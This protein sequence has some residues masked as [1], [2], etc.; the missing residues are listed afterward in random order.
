MKR[1]C[2]IAGLL[3]AGLLPFTAFAAEEHKAVT[4]D[5]LKWAQHPA[6]P[7]GIETA[8]VNGDP[9]KEGVYVFRLKFPAGSKV[10]P[11]F[12]PN[13]E[14]VTV[15]SGTFN[16]AMGDTFDE[17]SGQ[18][19]PVGGFFQAPKNA[20][21]YAWFDEDTVLQLH[22]IGPGGITYINPEDDPRK[23]Q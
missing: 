16:I 18:A 1:I 13:D 10:P 19:L 14:N 2:L 5:Q 7:K 11:H 12:H 22:G 21:H 20:H 9:S 23:T 3:I 6:L 15:L 4:P 8:I 17:S